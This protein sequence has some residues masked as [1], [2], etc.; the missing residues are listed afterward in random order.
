MHDIKMIREDAAGFDAAL[1]RRGIQPLSREI[2]ELDEQ[3]R[4]ALAKQQELQAE[5]N[6]ISKKI[7]EAKR[8]KQDSAVLEAD[9]TRLRGEI[10]ALDA[11]GPRLDGM[12]RDTLSKIPNLLDASVPDGKDE[13]ENKQEKL[14]GTPHEFAF[15][16]KQHF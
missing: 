13:T 1:G 7:G 12:L 4:A 16:P 11:E 8:N 14:W 2:L 6:A 10:E 9:G 3:R 15:A 5:R